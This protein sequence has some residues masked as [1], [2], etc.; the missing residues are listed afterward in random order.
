M[1]R[2]T[3]DWIILGLIAFTAGIVS[4]IIVPDRRG[5]LG[6]LAAAIVG[7]FTGGVAGISANA[8][9]IHPGAQYLISATAGFFGYKLLRWAMKWGAGAVTTVNISGGQN[10][11]GDRNNTDNHEH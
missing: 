8:Y 3:T 6:F 1:E 11:I 5:I 2:N 7:V 9:D 10:V 4:N